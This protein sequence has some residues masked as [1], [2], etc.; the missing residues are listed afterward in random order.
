MEDLTDDDVMTILSLFEDSDFDY[1]QF[2]SGDLKLT[3]SK[4]GFV[5]TPAAAPIPEAPVTPPSDQV[6]GAPP[7][8]ATAPLVDDQRPTSEAQSGATRQPQSDSA[9]REGLVPITA[10]IVGTFYAAP[11]PQSPTF[12]SI[13]DHV[14]DGRTIGLIEVMKVF[15]SVAAG[16]TGTIVEITVADAQLVEQGEVL[17]YIRPDQSAS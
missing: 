1:L 8:P 14:E 9:V 10:P 17:F 3:V 5:P 13:G 11:D 6:G 4:H 15:T 2:E 16:V 12:V 7:P